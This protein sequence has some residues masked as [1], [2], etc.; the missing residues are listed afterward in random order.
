MLSVA[1]NRDCDTIRPACVH[2]KHVSRTLSGVAR[3]LRLHC[4]PLRMRA[5][6]SKGGWLPDNPCLH[7]PDSCEPAFT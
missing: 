7:T 4:V 5:A 2:A 6:E 1:V 3:V